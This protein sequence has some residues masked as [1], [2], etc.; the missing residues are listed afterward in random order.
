MTSTSFEQDTLTFSQESLPIFLQR[1]KSGSFLRLPHPLPDIV[2]IQ[3][4]IFCLISEEF[5]ARNKLNLKSHTKS[6]EVKMKE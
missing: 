3:K 4:N 2:T 1:E 6:K 5:S